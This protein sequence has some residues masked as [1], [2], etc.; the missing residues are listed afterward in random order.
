MASP[1][2]GMD[3]YIEHPDVWSDFHGALAEGVRAHL[4]ARIRPRYVARLTPRVTYD[5]VEIDQVRGVAPDVAIW[6]R[7]VESR[8][9]GDIAAAATP[10][11]VESAIDL[12]LP[13][14]LYTVELRAIGTMELVT[15]IEILSPVN[16]RPGHEAC[17]DYLRKRKDLL[18]STAH[19]IEIDLL[20]GGTRPPLARPVPA[21]AYRITLSRAEQRPGVDVWVLQLPDPLPILP[22]PLRDPDPD[23]LLDLPG[24]LADVYERG[25]YDRL[26][27]YGQDVPPPSLSETE[28][29][30]VRDLLGRQAV[31]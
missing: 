2:P 14:R 10:A 20:R 24:V 3:P 21:S 16:K 25:G 7:R 6:Q 4:N 13:I 31:P 12:E 9:T 8:R 5:V 1:F 19:L 30:W 11:S 17:A 26:I 29:A 23:T 28:A 18:R 22:V 27:D 15:A